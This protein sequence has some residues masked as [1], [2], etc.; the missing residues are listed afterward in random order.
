MSRLHA[1]LSSMQELRSLQAAEAEALVR[2][3]GQVGRWPTADGVKAAGSV[4]RGEP[5]N[6]MPIGG[7]PAWVDPAMP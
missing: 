7:T 1:F 3:I 2:P 5:S 4:Q 6:G